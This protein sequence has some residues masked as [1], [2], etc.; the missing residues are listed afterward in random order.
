MGAVERGAGKE[1]LKELIKTFA[2]HPNFFSFLRMQDLFVNDKGLR[3]LACWLLGAQ[4]AL[5]ES[6]PFLECNQITWG[7]GERETH[8]CRLKNSDS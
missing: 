3:E 5:E 4:A 1:L 2:P 8:D 7:E 6:M